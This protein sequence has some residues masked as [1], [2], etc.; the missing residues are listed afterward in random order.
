MKISRAL[1]NAAVNNLVID[2]SPAKSLPNPRP[3]PR[4]QIW[5]AAEIAKLIETADAISKPAM[6]LAIRI[7]WETAMQPVDVR[8]LTLSERFSDARGVWFD[9]TRSKTKKPIVAAVSSDLNADIEAY[10]G[11][12]GVA[13]LP[14]QPFLRTS[15]DAHEYLK[16]RFLSD[17]RIVREAAFGKDEKRRFQDI[18]R[19]A[20]VEADLGSATP[21]E[22]AKLLANSLDKDASLDATYTPKTVEKSRQIAEKRL[23]GRR[24]LAIHTAGDRK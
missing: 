15:R 14:D 10:V 3:A 5:R 16:A 20:N 4:F 18:R 21:E 8:T 19:S 13:I 7:G 6:S 2:A 23:I 22:R 9:T 17:F 11:S 24:H 1:F 12:L